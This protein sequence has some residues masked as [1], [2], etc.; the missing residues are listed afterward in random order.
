[1]TKTNRS[2]NNSSSRRGD[3]IREDL[4]PSILIVSQYF[5][6]ETGAA[7]SRMGDLADY[8]HK[9]GFKVQVLT[10]IPNYP[11]GTFSKGYRLRWCITEQWKNILVKRAFV[12][13]TKRETFF[14]RVVYFGSF[15]FSSL[16][17]GLGLQKVDYVIA[18]SPSP[19]VGITGWILSRRYKAKFVLDIRDLWPMAVV[20]LSNLKTSFVIDLLKSVERFLYAKASLITIAVPGFRKYINQHGSNPLHILDF[21]NGVNSSFLDS[22][23]RPPKTNELENLN[24]KFIVLFSGNHGLAYDLEMVLAAASRLKKNTEIHFLFVGD[25]INKRSLQHIAFNNSLPNVTFVRSQPR[26]EMPYII[27]FAH[28]CL[29]P[30]KDVPY[31]EKAL[32]SSMFEY[33]ACKKP[34]IVTIKGEAEKT[35]REANAGLII[36]AGNVN[37][38]INAITYLIEHQDERRAMG[39]NGYRFVRND[40]NQSIILNG[41]CRAL[42]AIS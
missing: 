38:L 19:F 1:M 20:E 14:Q 30:L 25:G 4:S 40:Y 35:I 34:V 2:Y 23:P 27:H 16:I 8:L 7:A 21:P 5:P 26:E 37:E 33:L 17:I 24:E 15:L 6:P 22:L 10:E 39:R 42:R 9:N 41:F 11:H 28:V 36:E 31:L 13:P 32:P 18:T 3:E 12:I 29:L